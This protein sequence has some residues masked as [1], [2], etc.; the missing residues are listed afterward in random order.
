MQAKYNALKTLKRALDKDSPKEHLKKLTIVNQAVAYRVLADKSNGEITGIEYKQ[1]Q[2]KDSPNYTTKVAKGRYYV[3]AASAIENAK[4]LL[5]SDI[6][7]SSDQVGRNLMDHLV[8]LTWGLTKEKVY[9]YRGPGSTSNIPT[10]RNGEFRKEHAAWISPF[11]NWG[12]SWPVFSPGADLNNA[13]G[14]GLFGKAL[15]QRLNNTVTRQF[16]LHFEVEQT[17]DPDNRVTIDP[18]YLDAIGNYR[19]VVHYNVGEYMLKAFEAAKIVSDQIFDANEI[20]DHTVYDPVKDPG[21]TVYKGKGYTYRGAGHIVGTHRMGATK[22]D[23]VVDKEQRSWDHPNLFL[24]GCGNMPTLGTSNPTLTMAALT[25]RAAESLL[26]LLQT[27]HH[28]TENRTNIR[29]N[30]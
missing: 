24:V 1:Y 21:Y 19:P 10:F 18:A 27:S 25:F 26:T 2:Y 3:L 17:P 6:A 5:A 8:M 29:T 30:K 15:R 13:L 23:S 7:N 11:D 14:E 12:W 9:P 16:L 4:L 28:E 20:E 22:E